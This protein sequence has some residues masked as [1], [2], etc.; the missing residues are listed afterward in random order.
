LYAQFLLPESIG[1]SIVAF[2]YLKVVLIET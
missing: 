2:F 1:I